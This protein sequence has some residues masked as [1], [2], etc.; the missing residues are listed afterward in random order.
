MSLVD[1]VL[2]LDGKKFV[3]EDGDEYVVQLSPGLSEIEI[4]AY[5]RRLPCKIPTHIKNL[6]SITAGLGGTLLADIDFSGKA[7]GQHLDQLLPY[8]LP[9]ANDGF[10][11]SWNVD[12]QPGSTDWGPI[13]FVCHDAPVML[14]QSPNL[15]NFINE[16]MRLNMP[17]YRGLIDDVH[18]DKLYKVWATNPGTLSRESALTHTDAEI[19]CFAQ[20]LSS[21]CEIIDMRNK[22][23][24]YG[25]SW[26]R[27]GPQTKLFRHGE[28]AIFAYEKRKSFLQKLF[29]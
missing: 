7:N 8:G 10:G 1:L 26:G 23:I 5:E 25:L 21:D 28:Q 9:I 22:P 4:N 11:N 2:S 3:S 29:K 15:E 19:A 17:P 6:L 14:L 13:Y 12:L 16:V 18:E 24:G 27:Y 20:S